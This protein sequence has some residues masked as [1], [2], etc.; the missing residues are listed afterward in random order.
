MIGLAI[1]VLRL[2]SSASDAV[3]GALPKDP[4]ALL[5]PA[6]IQALA[7]NAKIG[8]GVLDTSMAPLGFACTYT[9]GPRTREWGQSA[10]TITVID[11]SKGW[12]GVSPDQIQQGILAKVKTGGPNAS[13]VPGVGDAAAFTFEARVSNATAEAYLK[14]KGVH[15][16]VTFH[17]GD[18]L[19][20]KDKVIALLKDAAARL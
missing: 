18:S 6:E 2:A 1:V 3:A 11:A 5:K 9:W 15:L 19:S 16:S 14:A 7:S 12:A 13:Q 4:C 20:N 17:A 8:S 10:L